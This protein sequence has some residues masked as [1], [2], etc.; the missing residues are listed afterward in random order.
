MFANDM[1]LA[2]TVERVVAGGME[3]MTNAPYLLLKAPRGYR[4]GQPSV[5]PHGRSMAWRACDSK[6]MGASPRTAANT[7]SRARQQDAF[8]T[9]S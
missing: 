9:Q 4:M 1:L 2:G 8:A 3:S 5:R 7:G 6:A